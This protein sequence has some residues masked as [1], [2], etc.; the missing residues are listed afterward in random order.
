MDEGLD[1]FGVFDLLRLKSRNIWTWG[2]LYS[3]DV[4]KRNNDAAIH[5][6]PFAPAAHPSTS[7][8]PGR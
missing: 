4:T 8:G 2:L 7:L 5:F 1:T 3:M 6:V